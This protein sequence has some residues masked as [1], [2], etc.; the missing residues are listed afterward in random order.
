[1]N[2]N[3]NE[4]TKQ[5]DEIDFKKWALD[6]MQSI[7]TI[8]EADAEAGRYNPRVTGLDLAACQHEI[9]RNLKIAF[10]TGAKAEKD[11]HRIVKP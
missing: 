8:E 1:M 7:L 3:G 2:Q 6:I 11:T 10:M 4:S 9:T 5:F